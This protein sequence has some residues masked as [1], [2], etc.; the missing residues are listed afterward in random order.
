MFYEKNYIC[1][2]KLDEEEYKL[3]PEIQQK[4]KHKRKYMNLNILLM[5][6]SDLLNLNLIERLWKFM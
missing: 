5:L 4:E 3:L 6:H 1:S 2:M